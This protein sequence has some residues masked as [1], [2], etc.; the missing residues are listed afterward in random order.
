M[1]HEG[2]VAVVTGGAKGIGGGI[3]ERLGADGASVVVADVD[4]MGARELA[5]TLGDRGHAVRCDVTD[6]AQVEAAVQAAFDRFGRLDIMVNNAGIVHVAPLTETTV[7]DWDRIFDI[8]VKGMFLGSKVAGRR[9]VEQGEGGCIVNAASGAGR[10]GVPNFSHYCATKASAIILSQSLALELAPHQ[11]RVNCYA[12]GHTM[13]PLWDTIAE[14]FG[15][16]QGLT[17]DETLKMFLD[18]VPMGRFGTPA[19][20]AG[21]VSWL[22]SE[23]ASYV[24]GQVIAMNGGELP[25]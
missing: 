1:R 6:E 15:A 2:K 11:I 13:T 5:A 8:N 18:S 20:V 24:T 3:A 4:E 12:P 19:D 22:C 10:H 25:W 9:L 23:D 17:R 7:A 14:Q 16:M 21:A